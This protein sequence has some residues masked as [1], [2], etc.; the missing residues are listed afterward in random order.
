MNKRIY[1]AIILVVISC[2]PLQIFKQQVNT[3]VFV[4]YAQG[5]VFG[6]DKRLI[7]A[8]EKIQNETLE[9]S[10]GALADFQILP[11]KLKV[12]FSAGEET[13]FHTEKSRFEL[14]YGKMD[15][16]FSDKNTNDW[17]VIVPSFGIIEVKGNSEDTGFTI[18][19]SK[20]KDKFF[21][22][23]TDG[24]VALKPIH[25]ELIKILTSHYVKKGKKIELTLSKIEKLIIDIHNNPDKKEK[26]FEW[27]NETPLTAKEIERG[28]EDRKN[29]V[30]L[31]DKDLESGN[32]SEI[33]AQQNESRKEY[34]TKKAVCDSGEDAMRF[35]L[36]DGTIKLGLFIRQEPKGFILKTLGNEEEL[37]PEKNIAK[38][39]YGYKFSALDC[40]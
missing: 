33:I 29:Q 24:E 14:Q 11:A 12:K 7:S 25:P 28:R 19:V 4:G 9:I 23:V 22:E 27:F 3:E 15:F 26:E 40:K 13:I 17:E 37:L 2:N 16:F 5:K 31:T 36:K 32:I 34:I 30:F 35:Q 20:E 8:N 10:K 39:L 18:K 6:N 21:L 38:I 1:T